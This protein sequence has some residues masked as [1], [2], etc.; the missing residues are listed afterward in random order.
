[1]TALVA[2]PA[3]LPS[4]LVRLDLET[5]TAGSRYVVC[6]EVVELK[7]YWGEL[8][9]AGT[10]MLTDV[11]IRVREVWKDTPGKRADVVR[12]KPADGSASDRAGDSADDGAEG[13]LEEI[14]IQLLGGA[15]GE[16]WQHCPESPRFEKGEE[17]LVFAREFNGKLWATGW[18]QGKYRLG[19][20]RAGGQTVTVVHGHPELPVRENTPAVELRAQVAQIVERDREKARA[21]SLSGKPQ[22]GAEDAEGSR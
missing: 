21:E 20:A 9:D 3:S 14:T 17:V 16:R 11:R 4:A 18:L 1:L 13:P 5:L 6:G 2:F 10:V 12:G 19:R 8:L 7:S 22:G 15:I